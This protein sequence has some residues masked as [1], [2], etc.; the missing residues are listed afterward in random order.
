[1]E[2][3]EEWGDVTHQTAWAGIHEGPSRYRDHKANRPD[4]Y[5][6]LT[7]SEEAVFMKAGQQGPQLSARVFLNP[8][9]VTDCACLHKGWSLLLHTGWCNTLLFPSVHLQ[10][11]SVWAGVPD[12]HVWQT[13][14]A[15][16]SHTH[17]LSL[18]L[19]LSLSVCMQKGM[20][21]CIRVH[22]RQRVWSVWP[23]AGLEFILFW[24]PFFGGVGG[25]GEG[26]QKSHWWL[27]LYVSCC[28]SPIFSQFD[29]FVV[30][31]AEM[32]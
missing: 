27:M 17:S 11:T 20:C 13:H 2:Q 4:S 26:L 16:N 5:G 14:V 29:F 15:T 18:S 25:G 31:V 8:D 12:L 19:S 32:W 30:T 6:P 10:T 24:F 28:N 3:I 22:L 9:L 7:C 1:M 21:T 23:V